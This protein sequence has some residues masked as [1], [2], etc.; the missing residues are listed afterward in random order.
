[1]EHD[2]ILFVRLRMLFILTF[3]VLS[4]FSNKYCNNTLD[5]KFIANR[6]AYQMYLSNCLCTLLFK[7]EETMRCSNLGSFGHVR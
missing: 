6:K 5:I 1:M 4:I 2:E 7:N 3:I